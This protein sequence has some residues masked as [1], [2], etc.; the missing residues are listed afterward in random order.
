MAHRMIIL[1][2]GLLAGHQ[3]VDAA[4][5][6]LKSKHTLIQLGKP[7]KIIQCTT[8]EFHLE[9]GARI[10]HENVHW[11]IYAL[12]TLSNEGRVGI[13]K[14]QNKPLRF[15]GMYI[16]GPYK[17]TKSRVAVQDLQ[18]CSISFPIELF[19]AAATTTTTIAF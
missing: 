15:S 5:T 17:Y 19:A 13:T 10:S 3:M 8:E 1:I 2:V 14:I 6:S 12:L 7:Y 9:N 4:S 18:G 11:C 16:T